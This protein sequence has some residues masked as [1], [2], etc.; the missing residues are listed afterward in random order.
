[1]AKKNNRFVVVLKEG[2]SLSNEGYRQLFVDRQTG[3]TYLSIHC[4]YGAGL[5]PVL[6]PDGSP[7]ITRLDSLGEPD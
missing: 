1:M 5:T 2:N 7:F 4:G 3:V 6:N